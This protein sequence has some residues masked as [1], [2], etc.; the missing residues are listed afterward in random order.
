MKNRRVAVKS[1]IIYSDKWIMGYP[2]ISE[3]VVKTLKEIVP[4]RFTDN[5]LYDILGKVKVKEVDP[6][7]GS[8]TIVSASRCAANVL[9]N[10][11][12]NPS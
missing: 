10:I 12:P 3:R 8:D 9:I 1:R 6:L 7:L 4:V 5:R 11:E 2:N